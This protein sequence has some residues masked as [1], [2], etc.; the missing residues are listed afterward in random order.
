MVCYLYPRKSFLLLSVIKGYKNYKSRF[1]LDD[2]KKIFIEKTTKDGK[3]G[4]LYL[5]EYELNHN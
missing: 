5:Y 4:D 1:N 2:P 3:W